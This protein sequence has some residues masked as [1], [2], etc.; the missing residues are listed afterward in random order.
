MR[1]DHNRRAGHALSTGRKD[2]PLITSKTLRLSSLTTNPRKAN[3]TITTG[4]DHCSSRPKL[5]GS[6]KSPTHSRPESG[7]FSNSESGNTRLFPQHKVHSNRKNKN[8]TG[9]LRFQQACAA[10]GP[11]TSS[12]APK[13]RCCRSRGWRHRSEG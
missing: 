10:E 7:R 9:S 13:K 1:K 8:K 2:A 3:K 5:K 6:R 11:E 4:G 12:A